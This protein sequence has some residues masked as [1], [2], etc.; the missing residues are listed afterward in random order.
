MTG[1]FYLPPE[2]K[3]NSIEAMV[4]QNP[5]I[6]GLQVYEYFRNNSSKQ[7][8]E[9][10]SGQRVEL[11]LQYPFLTINSVEAVKVPMLSALK[12]LMPGEKNNKSEALYS[13]VEYRYTELFM[14]D[15]ARVMNSESLSK[16]EQNEAR[17]YFSIANEALYGAPNKEIFSALAKKTLLAQVETSHTDNTQVS[18]I[19]DELNSLLGVTDNSD[20]VTFS[21]TPELVAHVGSLVHERFDDLV[22]HVDPEKD[23]DV[24][25]MAEALDISLG[26]LGAKDMGWK[27]SIVPNSTAMAVSAHQKQVQ[28]GQDRPNNINGAVFRG[29]IIHEVGVHAGRSINAERDGWLSAVYGQDGYL[30]FEEAFATALEDAYKGEFVEHGANYYLAAGLAY[31]LDNHEPRNFAEVHSI[32]WRNNALKKVEDGS[33]TEKQLATAKSSAFTTCIRFFRGTDTHQKG[34]IYLKDL[35]YFNGQESAW[36]YLKN[37]S[38]QVDFEIAFAGKLDITRPDHLDIAKHI[39]NKR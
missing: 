25:A 19:R 32:L 12:I 11:D 35:A 37:V 7:K 24:Q 6:A 27:I 36:E 16:E 17:K 14:M 39:I 1:E 33:L 30:D 5:E 18:E 4:E 21:P 20:F 23:Y 13:A 2:Q 15:M 22:D 29:K 26:K 8:E 9:F 10:L 31:G 38:N 34:I 3:I 28:I